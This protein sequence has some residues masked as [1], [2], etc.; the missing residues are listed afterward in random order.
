MRLPLR[1]SSKT[2]TWSVPLVLPFLLSACLVGPLDTELGPR[3]RSSG[4]NPSVSGGGGAGGSWDQNSNSGG[5]EAG[6]T[7]ASGGSGGS[8]GPGGNGGTAPGAGGSEPGSGGASGGA[9]DCEQVDCSEAVQPAP[10]GDVCFEFE[11]GPFGGWTVSNW[12]GCEV[13]YD[14]EPT[15]RT[16]DQN[17]GA[18]THTLE[19]RGC[20]SP[21]ASW[22]C[23]R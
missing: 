20:E 18:G 15:S 17:V 8:P 2:A 12:L 21:S 7:P 11:T 23:W 10:L 6:G 3:P 19:F 13:R 22:T 14:G 9:P 1:N 4:G 5:T 16:M